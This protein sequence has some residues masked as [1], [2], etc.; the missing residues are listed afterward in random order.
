MCLDLVRGDR[1]IP[2]LPHLKHQMLLLLCLCLCVRM[3]VCVWWRCCHSWCRE[4]VFTN[5]VYEWTT[6]LLVF[7]RQLLLTFVPHPL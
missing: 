2:L 3:S 1:H 5:W 6:R 7:V 4:P